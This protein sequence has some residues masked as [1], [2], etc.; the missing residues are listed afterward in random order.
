MAYSDEHTTALV[1]AC[2]A[3]GAASCLHGVPGC[4]QGRGVHVRM[5]YSDEL[6][7]PDKDTLMSDELIMPN[8]DTMMRHE[9]RV[10]ALA[11]YGTSRELKELLDTITDAG[12]K[13]KMANLACPESGTTPLI[14]GCRRDN[15]AIAAVLIENGADPHQANKAGWTPLSTATRFASPKI[16]QILE[17]H[18]ATSPSAVTC[19]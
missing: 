12:E 9:M 10:L 5:A 1:P 13:Q 3:G 19:L 18:R 2:N 8:M 17:K 16:V 7:M 4:Y 14:A 15:S 11:A 6:L